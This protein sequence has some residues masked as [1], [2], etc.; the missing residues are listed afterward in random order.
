MRQFAAESAESYG[1]WLRTD[2]DVWTR[3]EQFELLVGFAATLAEDLFR[4][5]RL[6][7]FAIDA[8][9][10]RPV[11]RVHDLERVLDRLAEA[12]PRDGAEAGG[13]AVPATRQHVLTF[14]PDGTRGV[15][16][17]LDGQTA[18]SA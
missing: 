2:A 4:G 10:P 12:R 3:P 13:V 16:A 18:A 14:S 1:I 6:R 17:T 15:I 7:E 5:G 9:P 8:E 11:R